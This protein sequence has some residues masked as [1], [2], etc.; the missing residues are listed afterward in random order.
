MA[1]SRIT[2]RPAPVPVP[3]RD[4][5]AETLRLLATG[6]R[7]RGT[8]SGHEAERLAALAG[9]FDRSGPGSV[10][11]KRRQGWYRVG[12]TE[13]I[14]YHL[15]RPVG[16]GTN[17]R[18]TEPFDY[19]DANG[20]IFTVP[21]PM[22]TD[23]ASIPAFASWLVPK[24]GVH[25]QAAL[26]HDSM[27][28]TQEYFGPQVTE[29]VADKMFREAMD[30][31]HVGL[32]RR[33]LMWTAVSLPTIAKDPGRAAWINRPRLVLSVLAFA[34]FGLFALPDVLDF[35]QYLP[36]WTKKGH[37]LLVLA[38]LG[39]VTLLVGIF[40]WKRG[41]TARRAVLI[42]ILGLG[43]AS[44]LVAVKAPPYVR[45]TVMN[46]LPMRVDGHV[47]YPRE[48]IEIRQGKRY[49]VRGT[50]IDE[51]FVADPKLVPKSAP[52][53][54]AEGTTYFVRD[55]G[56]KD[57]RSFWGEL[58]FFF[59]VML[60]LAVGN[61][62]LWIDWPGFGFFLAVGLGLVAFAMAFVLIAFAVNEAVE[63]LVARGVR[64]WRGPAGPKESP[65]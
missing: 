61:T 30:F 57:T 40:V 2:R 55:I 3:P 16:G 28:G 6:Y 37:L 25:T 36:D 42:S 53:G 14:G 46:L 5:T 7:N 64:A 13:R 19:V 26:V 34:F 49:L 23:L 9:K 18:V 52:P 11:P 41:P 32:V 45:T 65:G 17:Y 35:P 43:V 15:E 39:A 60:L 27:I 59:V 38:G 20:Q 10:F 8:Q 50:M 63:W 48:V 33:W 22:A 54:I 29:K 4:M 56:Q 12:S 58:W 1:R 62:V 44:A 47:H 51:T 24:D 31:V 21:A